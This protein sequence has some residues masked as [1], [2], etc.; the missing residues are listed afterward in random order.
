[1]STRATGTFEGKSWDEQP[2]SQIDGGSK[3]A[4][5]AVVNAFHGDIEGEGTLEYLLVYVNE[6]DGRFIGLEQVTGRVGGRAGSFVLEHSGTFED[7]EVE[8]AWSVVPS[9][10]TGE[11]RGL[12]GE[13]G[14]VASNGPRASFTLDYDFE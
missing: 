13:G 8:G 6:R 10:G 2:Y 4:R 5:A 3:L 7:H 9:S 1:M 14:F 11:L 12:R